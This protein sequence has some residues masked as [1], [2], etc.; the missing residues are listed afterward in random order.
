MT[1][2]HSE[3][4]SAAQASSS[5]LS[6]LNTVLKGELNVLASA[7]TRTSKVLKS[8]GTS[9]GVSSRG[10]SF[11]DEPSRQVIM[12]AFAEFERFTCIRFVAYHGQR[13]FVSILPMAG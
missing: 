12:E 9:A 13:D 8:Y 4:L 5:A 6:S 1:R 2:S 10:V 11:P 3:G 7:L